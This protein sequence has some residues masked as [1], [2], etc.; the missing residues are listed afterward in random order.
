[1]KR[2][3]KNALVW[4]PR[5]TVSDATQIGLWE[6]LNNIGDVS[7]ETSSISL[8]GDVSEICN[9]ALFELSLGLCMRH[10]KDASE[11]HPCPYPSMPRFKIKTS[12]WKVPIT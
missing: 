7:E 2:L 1:M 9:S 11:M 3:P 12:N 8:P 4:T 5:I 6:N 10:L